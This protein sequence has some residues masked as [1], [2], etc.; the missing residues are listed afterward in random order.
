MHAQGGAWWQWRQ[1]CGDPHS[2]HLDG[3]TWVPGDTIVHLHNMDCVGDVALGPTE[4]FLT[5]LGRGYPRVAPGRIELLQSDPESGQL[6]LEARSAEAG[7]RLVLWTPTEASTHEAWSE[8]LG[9]ITEDDVP[10]GRLLT[11]TVS[12]SG[13]YSIGVEPR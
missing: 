1:P 8:G 11:A 7:A 2:L 12:A 5:L 13:E 9:E 4:E 10:G 3:D 6:V